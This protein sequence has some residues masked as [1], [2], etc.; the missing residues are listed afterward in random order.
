MK[1]IKTISDLMRLVGYARGFIMGI[2]LQN[3]PDTEFLKQI[4]KEV[5]DY[6]ELEINRI[7]EE[8]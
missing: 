2:A 3:N 5:D 8:S 1:D 6:I 7:M 4:A